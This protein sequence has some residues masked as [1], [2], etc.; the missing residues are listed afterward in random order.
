MILNKQCLAFIF[1]LLTPLCAHSQS[2]EFNFDQKPRWEAGLGLGYF[3]GIDYPGSTDPNIAAF[4]L[5]F[6]I[7]RSRVFRV[8]DGGVGAV[9]VEQPRLK[10]DVSFGGSLNAKSENDSVRAGLPDLDILF[11]LGPRLQFRLFDKQLSNGS[12]TE[13]TWDSKARA[14]VATDFKRIRAQGFVL[15]TG[16][17]F[18]QRAIAGDKV[19][20]I[21]NADIIF[22]DQRYN[23]NLYT[24]ATEF[25]TPQRP[26]YKAK[27]GYVESSLFLGFAIKPIPNLRVFTGIAWI[28]YAN[29][30]NENSPLFET[31]TGKQFAVGVVWSAFRS[32]RSID[33]FKS[34]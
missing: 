2:D 7:Y 1:T 10:L 4:A 19:D 18:R 25:S 15:G 29:S 32:K 6:F 33:V 30:A 27:A 34:E 20:M 14:V 24:V 21:A 22:G 11:E 13:L 17:G 9:A 23:D 28:S 12:R 26:E 5:P 16:L 3:N 31:K 8:G